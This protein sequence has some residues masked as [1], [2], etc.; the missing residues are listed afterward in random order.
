MRILYRALPLC[1][2][3]VCSLLGLCAGAPPASGPR[4]SGL[5]PLP[6]NAEV[7]L[8]DRPPG[9]FA[10]DGG[11]SPVIFPPEELS[12]RFNHR[13]HVRELGIGCTTCHDRAPRSKQSSDSLLPPPTRCDACH[14]SNH[15]NLSAVT[16]EPDFL[17]SQCG[18]CHVGYKP[19][20]GN[21]VA[22]MR[23]PPPNLK[24]N[25]AAHLARNIG[26][27]QCHG[28]VD[29]IELATRDQLPRMRGCFNCHQLP[30]PARGEA[31]GECT[32]CHLT[33]RGLM[34][35]AFASGRLVPPH[36]LHDAGHGADWIERHK[37]IAGN[38]SKLCAT[39]HSEKY[40]VDCHDGR[41]RPRK[42]HPNDWI[43]MHPMAARQNS[44]N[45]T[46]CHRQQSFCIGCHQ[47]AGVTLSGPYENFAGRGRFHPPKS[48]W[49][50]P[51]RSSGHH[52]WEAQRNLAACVSCHVERD[53]AICHSTGRVG[54]RGAGLPGDRGQGVNPHPVGFKDRC[55]G[56]MRRNARPCLVCHDPADPK[57]LECR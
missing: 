6:G 4:V 21:K 3:S 43:S 19:G 55:S 38:D 17:I 13:K 27:A 23:M 30:A 40:C 9:A 14:H 33:E 36:W 7:P 2:L 49:T 51:P 8:A 22:R 31:R 18:F 29:S 10:G 12:I 53:C 48:V 32:T 46:S 45:C 28:N 11:P 20:D 37:R 44:P 34:K 25:H 56:A 15:R 52:S 41:V 24:M 16:S 5:A 1:V 35:T 57:L 42:V 54:G 26:C 50:D 39:C 47:R